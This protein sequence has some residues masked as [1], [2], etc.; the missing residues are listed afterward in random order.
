MDHSRRNTAECAMDCR[1]LSFVILWNANGLYAE[2]DSDC[3][4]WQVYVS[5]DGNS[6]GYGP[7]AAD[8]VFRGN[9]PDDVPIL[10][11]AV[12]G[13]APGGW[14]EAIAVIDGGAAFIDGQS[15]EAISDVP[16]FRIEG[17]MDGRWSA[18]KTGTATYSDSIVFCPSNDCGLLSPDCDT[19]LEDVAE[20]Q[21]TKTTWPVECLTG[22]T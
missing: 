22:P 1:I 9:A 4:A 16:L 17:Y 7:I 3:N 2:V 21:R 5:V 13:V 12:S 18:T 6:E 19:D 14:G 20:W 10:R 11:R 15:A 8:F